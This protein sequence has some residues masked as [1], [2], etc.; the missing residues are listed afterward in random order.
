[1][2]AK[3]VIIVILVSFFAG[4]FVWSQCNAPIGFS[5]LRV[6]KPAQQPSPEQEL[7]AIN[8]DTLDADFA[9]IDADLNN[10]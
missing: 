2:D 5:P 8:V 3:K 10:L 4:Y 1:M 9:P 6:T 7:G